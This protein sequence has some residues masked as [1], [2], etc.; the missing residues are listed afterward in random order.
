MAPRSFDSSFSPS[1]G[2]RVGVS[3]ERRAELERTN[4]LKQEMYAKQKTIQFSNLLERASDQIGEY[5]ESQRN[6]FL[7]EASAPLPDD[8]EPTDAASVSGDFDDFSPNADVSENALRF[9]D[10]EE[11]ESIDFNAASALSDDD[12]FDA[13]ARFDASRGDVD[14]FFDP[15]DDVF[16]S[17]KPFY[18]YDRPN[19]AQDELAFDPTARSSTTLR[20]HL[21]EQLRLDGR[22][23]DLSPVVWA[24]CEKIIDR[25]DSNGCLTVDAA[26]PTPLKD[27][28]YSAL[29]SAFE[30]IFNVDATPET[31]DA[32]R[33]ALAELENAATKSARDA[34]RRRFDAAVGRKTT[35]DER[36][37]F[38]AALRSIV[39]T[40][41]E[42]DGENG[43]PLDPLDALFPKKPSKKERDAAEKALAVVQTLDPP[44]VGARSLQ[45]SLLLRVR[46]D[47]PDAD[48]L[49]R[50]IAEAFD[51]FQKKRVSAIAEKTGI[52]FATVAA[53]YDA[54]FPFH[55]APSSLFSNESP[56]RL[57][58]PEIFLE[59]SPSGRW[60]ARLDDDRPEF[61]VDPIYRKMLLAKNVDK[62]TKEYLRRQYVDATALLDALQSRDSTVLRVAQAA[63]DFQSDYFDD[64]TAPARPLTLRQV[65][66]KIG[67]DPSTV[68]RACVDKWL[69]TPRGFVALK[70]LFP[71][72]VAGDVASASV[73]SRIRE[74]IDGEEKSRPLSDDALADELRRRFQIAVS[75]KTVQE[76]RDRLQIP[77][78][79]ARKRLFQ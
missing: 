74:L 18:R 37:R 25:L 36:E 53:I 68:S 61:R 58:R 30:T 3:A 21:L 51:D 45:E 60:R 12:D 9:D 52:P 23:A 43:A 59:K 62:A 7:V 2:F 13:A 11:T 44:G 34:F 24:L 57:I 14:E 17:S 79:R 32:A 75:R 47:V 5:V 29:Q 54:G 65:A 48:S 46:D 10:A 38:Q 78:S 41:D 1:P 16:F 31:L 73:E 76:Y 42:N 70:T 8:G 19:S 26:A 49:R 40:S 66:D 50:I 55:P 71:K 20:D 64:A 6:V 4:R 72:A 28:D 63:V 56:T 69:A 77:N 35:A 27:D 15:A 39:A 33:D 22:C 67:L